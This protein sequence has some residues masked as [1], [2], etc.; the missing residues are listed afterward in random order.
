MIRPFLIGL[1]A[2]A[3]T[4]CAPPAGPRDVEAGPK[5][6]D[7]YSLASEIVHRSQP[8]PPSTVPGQCWTHTTLPAVIETV[9]EHVETAPGVFRSVT[10]QRIV[11][12]S[13]DI[14]FRS[15]CPATMTADFIASLQ[16]A[17]KARGLYN[18]PLTG[19]MDGPTR[20][21]VRRYQAPL[22]LDTDK[23]SLGAA[24]ELG[25]ATYSL[26]DLRHQDD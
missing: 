21:A 22:G 25:L 14:W 13:R 17:L 11:Q 23:L 24:R 7:G 18:A 9:S 5:D 8:G 1:S 26:W 6:I 12:N 19:E 4:A 2:L 20:R 16:R 10:D 3:L 15:P